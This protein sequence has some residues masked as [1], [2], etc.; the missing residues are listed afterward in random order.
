[1]F[2][3]FAS[4][5]QESSRIRLPRSLNTL[6]TW[7]F[8]LTGHIL[9]INVIPGIHTAL[10]TQ[11]IFV[12]LP[13]VCFGMLLNYQVK[14]L[15]ESL[16]NVAG[17]TPNYT[18]HLLKK[19][20]LIA[21]Y[22]ALGYFFSWVSVLPV[23][24][25]VL[26][27]LIRVNLETIHV[28][29]PTPIIQIGLTLLPFILAF[30][31]TRGLGILHLFFIL[32]AFG[33]LVMF[34]AQG[35]GW[36]IFSPS[37]P[38]FF[39][40]DWSIP[41]FD[42]WAK[43]FLYVSYATYA[44]ETASAFVADSRH[45]RKTLSLL[46]LAAW[47]M[48]PIYLC[49]SWVVTRLG[50][51]DGNGQDSTFLNLLVT[52]LPFWGN[53]AGLIITFLIAA[54]CLLASATVVSNCPRI[55]YQLAIDQ[56]LSPVFAVVSRRGVLGPALTL[57][58]LL[59]LCC[60]IWGNVAQILIVGNVGWFISIMAVHLGIWLQR[61]KSKVLFP[62]LTLGILIL[63]VAVLLVGGLAW[64]LRDFLIGLFIPFVIIAIDAVIYN[65]PLPLCQPS[66][67]I[68]KYNS[69][70]VVNVNELL[71]YQ[72]VVLITLLS[73]AV[74]IGWLLGINLSQSD[75]QGAGNLV[76]VL[77]MI[78]V[79]VGVA[80]ACW[81]SLPPVVAIAEAQ[82]ATEHFFNVAQD[83]ILVV[84]EDGII[85]KANSAAANLFAPLPSDL[86]GNHLNKW[87]TEL[88][89]NPSDWRKRSEHTLIWNSQV[90][91]LE[92]SISDKS[93]Q[94]F[95]E[96]VVIVHDITKR[97]QAEAILQKSEAQLRQQAQQLAAQLIQSE[98][99]SSLGQ[100]VAGVAHEINN[101]VSF[102]YSNLEP[103]EEYIQDLI[104]LL[105]MYEHY[106]PQPVPEIQAETEAIEL[107]YLLKDLPK[108]LTSM[109]VGAKRISEIVKSLRSFSR[110]DEAEVKEVNIHEGLDNTLLILE[111]RLKPH[112]SL[113][114]I[115][116][117]KE[118]GELP[119]VE[120]YA[121]QIN[122][123]FMNILVNAIDALEL[124]INQGNLTEPPEIII[125]TATLDHHQ[126]MISIK[127]NGCG[128]SDSVQ[129]HLFE[130]FF[131]TK[132]VGKGTGLG[133]S[134]SYQII[135]EQ[136][137]GK[138]KCISTLHQGTEFLITIPRQQYT[139]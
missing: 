57:T 81:T 87:L 21:R 101:P 8:S 46:P 105:Q 70:Q 12:W 118:Y 74:I 135:T 3:Q 133:L 95:P 36:L 99:M 86:L 131:T 35:M 37:S 84:D 1:M 68:K 108:L 127:D 97:Q 30:S 129:K 6:E 125:K 128:M 5:A 82:Q 32:P 106:Y 90:K 65:L 66:W 119:L 41:S 7:G 132:P 116:V 122:Q 4:P 38:D 47:L 88:S 93:E 19:H 110:L 2:K 22:A 53:F 50:V 138:L 120:C 92:V 44:C 17:G 54:S 98:K 75:Y 28:S 55:L 20:P 113:P 80:I 71:L 33:L 137:R 25:I 91:T 15:G 34:A 16:L 45:P 134:I 18:C 83:G 13:A 77:L 111:N 130:P 42:V 51:V 72:V 126:V 26:T 100:L 23:N 40:H 109:R 103:A 89:N 11:A 58:L 43:W 67:W 94:D 139:S 96:Y 79:F 27:D 112:G 9:W 52:A 104:R 14:H 136:H 63:E 69:R 76:V 31:G 59:S 78:V 64:G 39:P 121:G 102:I 61:H 60:L 107:N 85:C 73:G 115:Q 49:A 117:T 24:A 48:I 29:F 56:H 62:R 123:V 124:A 10:N 114:R